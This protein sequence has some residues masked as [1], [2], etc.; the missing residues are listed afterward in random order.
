MSL[1]RVHTTLPAKVED[2]WRVVPT[3]LQKI[4]RTWFFLKEDVHR[5]SILGGSLGEKTK[6]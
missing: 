6:R 4:T 5:G 2:C 3:S 1:I